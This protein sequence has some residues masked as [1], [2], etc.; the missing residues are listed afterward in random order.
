MNKPQHQH[1]KPCATCP[2][3]RSVKPGALGGASTSK[4]IGQANGPF[5]LPCHEREGY[6]AQRGRMGDFSMPHCVGAAVFRANISRRPANSQELQC[7]PD[8]EAVFSSNEE[9]VAHHEGISVSEAKTALALYPVSLMVV[10]ELREAA[11]KGAIALV[12]RKEGSHE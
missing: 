12:P 7:P 5:Y 11:E 8:K 4:F 9:F 10:S 3:R 6:S 2:F 1:T